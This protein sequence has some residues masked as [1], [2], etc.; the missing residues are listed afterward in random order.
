MCKQLGDNE[1]DRERRE[2]SRQ[3]RGQATGIVPGR[4]LADARQEDGDDVLRFLCVGKQG[5]KRE[6]SESSGRERGRGALQLCQCGVVG[7]DS[8]DGGVRPGRALGH[9]SCEARGR[10]D[11]L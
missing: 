4:E 2:S 11:E 8:L 6:R 3:E 5:I 9:L 10:R 7:R 1:R